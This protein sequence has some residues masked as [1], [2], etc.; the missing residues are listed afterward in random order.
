MLGLIVLK[1]K[2]NVINKEAIDTECMQKQF[3][4]LTTGNTVIMGKR[5]FENI[6]YPSSKRLYNR[7]N[8][9][10]SRTT[11]YSGNNIITVN[12]LSKAL[13]LATDKAYVIGGSRIYKEVLPL[14]DI[15]YITE[16]NQIKDG[17][18]FF[19]E[20]NEEDFDKN[21]IDEDEMYKRYVYT[22][23]RVLK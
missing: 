12:S 10:V 3:D 18:I 19:P 14:V 6:W 2:N 11:R 23:K 7:L 4:E 16:T 20:F 22:R 13:Y 8:L 5:T 15:M 21:L 9:V 1:Y 17:N